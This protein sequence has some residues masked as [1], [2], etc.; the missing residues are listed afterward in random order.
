VRLAEGDVPGALGVLPSAEEKAKGDPLYQLFA[1]L[2]LERVGDAGCLQRY[3]AAVTSDGQLRVARVLRARALLA[4][5]GPEALP[6]AL[7]G[8]DAASVE[9]KALSLLSEAIAP[10]AGEGQ[11]EAGG[12]QQAL[13][14]ETLPVVLRWIPGLWRARQALAAGRRDEGTKLLE[15]ALTTVDTP[16]GA[17]RIGEL[18]L[19][20]DSPNLVRRAALQ[21]ISL[22]PVHTPARLLAAR[23]AADM[24]RYDEVAKALEGLEAKSSDAL[25]LRAVVAYERGDAVALGDAVDAL[26]ADAPPVVAALPALLVGGALP[27]DLAPGVAERPE[28]LWGRVARVDVSILRGDLKTASELLAGEG[29]QASSLTRRV[30]QL[31]RLDG[32]HEEAVAA[33]RRALDASPTALSLLEHASCLLAAKKPDEARDIAESHAPLLGPLAPWIAVL[34]DVEQGRAPR[35]KAR[36]A[37]LTEPPQESPLALRIVVTRA[38]VAIGDRARGRALLDGLRR[39]APRHPE[40]AQLPA[41]L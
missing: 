35:A 3:Q 9:H 15:E 29:T 5:Q 2:A 8:L 14:A 13:A 36:A 20:A 4:M 21:A 23:A 40:I 27:K 12:S 17:V 6:R 7:E 34:A 1:G 39:Q 10:L 41:R 30:A 28:T 24:G 26:R 37:T 32:R 33:S 18:A 38:M 19:A 25:A 22:S 31:A 16:D 11:T